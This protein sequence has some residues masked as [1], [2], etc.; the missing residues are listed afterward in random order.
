MKLRKLFFR[1]EVMQL[2]TLVCFS[3][4]GYGE[5]NLLTLDECL[6]LA[7]SHNLAVKVERIAVDKSQAEIEKE[8]GAFDP[9][10]EIGLS[11]DELVT[12]LSSEGSVAAAG[13]LKSKIPLSTEYRL[14]LSN[15]ASANNFNNFNNEYNTQFSLTLTQ[16][17]LRNSGKK[18]ALTN[19]MVARYNKEISL[20]DLREKALA[21]AARTEEAYWELVYA[22]GIWEIKEEV[23]KSAGK[24]VEDNKERVKA[25]ILS[26]GE[27]VKAKSKASTRELDLIE[28]EKEIKIKEMALKGLIY[29]DLYAVADLRIIPKDKPGDSLP[30]STLGEAVK[31]AMEKRQ[32]VLK[33]KKELEKINVQM[34]YRENQVKPTLNLE[35]NITASGFEK[36][37]GQSLGDN[38]RLENPSW[39]TGL[40]F[41]LPWG[42]RTNKAELAQAGLEAQRLI[43]ALKIKEQEIFTEIFNALEEVRTSARRIKV[44]RTGRELAEKVLLLENEKILA[45]MSSSKAILD[46][47]EDLA[48]S[49]VLEQKT[50]IDY[51]KA[52]VNLLKSQG[53]CHAHLVFAGKNK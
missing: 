1:L 18:M 25:G 40:V 49:K 41:S 36:S 7:M 38:W 21:I 24:L 48:D 10:L 47:Q 23:L 13:K 15:L 3:M 44:A 52:L 53:L 5:E 27:I 35:G 11:I 9:L 28:A 12:P 26:E 39:T 20:D 45:G 8:R 19:L 6:G 34:T 31:T 30:E 16:P 50:L 51:R 14:T 2:L 43:L 4:A 32:D 33:L 22:R 17:L 46:Y 42:D 29:P 37:F